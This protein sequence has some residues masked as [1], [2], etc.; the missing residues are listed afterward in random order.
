MSNFNFEE[1]S[2]TII[3]N[4]G[5]AKG[6]AINAIHLAKEN[7][8]DEAQ[9]ELE[10]AEKAMGIAGHSHMDVISAEAAGEKI[11]IPVLFMHA[12]DQLLTTETVILLSKEMIE[13]YKQLKK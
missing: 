6:R 1:I 8:F 10:L 13:L 7:K 5:E 4:A 2:F 11:Q 9:E 12:E 3:A